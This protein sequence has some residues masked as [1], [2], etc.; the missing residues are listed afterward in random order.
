[1]A[2]RAQ[3]FNLYIR[4]SS[5]RREQRQTIKNISRVA[6]T[7]N[8]KTVQKFEVFSKAEAFSFAWRFSSVFI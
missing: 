6:I 4:G 2:S 5:L 7:K 3:K 8:E 1:V